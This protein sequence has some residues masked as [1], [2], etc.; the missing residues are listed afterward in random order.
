MFLFFF[1]FLMKIHTCSFSGFRVYPG[2]GV[3]F[4]R[5]D[6]HSFIFFS[7]K[8]QHQFMVRRNPRDCAWTTLFRQQRRKGTSEEVVKKNK[9]RIQKVEK[10]LAGLSVE[11]L[12]SRRSQTQDVRAAAREAAIKLMKDRM[13]A[14][15]EKKAAEKKKVADA[16]AAEKKAAAETEK[17]TAD[18]KAEKK[19]QKAQQKKQ[20][21]QASKVKAPKSAKAKPTSL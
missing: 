20:K 14:A 12:R 17:K 18:K 3:R 19:A 9:R 15:A 16:K 7:K 5:G 1:V 10:G 2:R 11:E 21:P 8:S 6:A 4:V 13:K